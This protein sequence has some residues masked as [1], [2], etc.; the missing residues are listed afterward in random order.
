[1]FIPIATVRHRI[2]RHDSSLI[3]V[4]DNGVERKPKFHELKHIFVSQT[5]QMQGNVVKI[6]LPL[7]SL[8][9]KVHFEGNENTV[10][11]H[12]RVAGTCDILFHDNCGFVEIG[13][14]C[15]LPSCFMNV[16]AS[17]IRIGNDCMGAKDLTF[18]ANDAHALF[19]TESG[20]LLNEKAPPIVIGNHCWLGK[21]ASFTKNAVIPDDTIVG[22]NAVVT[23]TFTE[24][25]TAIAGVPA[26]V[27]HH[28]IGWDRATPA[29]FMLQQNNKMR[30]E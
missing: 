12:S 7:G 1:M 14:G 16:T 9:L 20:A 5:K 17:G 3:R 28:H 8:R 25:Y 15:T 19:D 4:I 21:G 6:E 23:K 27:V 2:L 26:K 10:T 22:M 13:Q 18:Y 11:I 29:Q 30:P 24:K